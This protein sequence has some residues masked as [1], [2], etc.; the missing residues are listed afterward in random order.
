M[1]ER[2]TNL[3]WLWT[4]LGV[5]W[6]WF[7]PPHF[8]WFGPWVSP[9]LGVIMLGMGLTLTFEDFRKVFQHP[10]AIGVGV[11][12]Q[13]LIM[14]TIGY[15]IA[16]LF[17]LPPSLAAGLVLVSC[18]PGGTASNVIAF[19]AKANVALSVLMTMCSTG[20]AIVLTPLMTGLSLI[21]I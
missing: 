14:P 18:C 3:F 1:L 7:F 12:A 15:S 13:F 17:G 8:A 9:G 19:L 2:F 21:H 11:F 20:L 16:K 5:T 6:A 10:Q 4:I